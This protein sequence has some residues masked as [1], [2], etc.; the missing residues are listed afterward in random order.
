MKAFCW[1]T[2]APINILISIT[3]RSQF[4]K[5]YSIS[6]NQGWHASSQL[7][8]NLINANNPLWLTKFNVQCF[9]MTMFYVPQWQ[10]S[11]FLNDNVLQCSMFHGLQGPLFPNV[12]RCK[13]SSVLNVPS[14]SRFPVPQCSMFLDDNVQCSMVFEVPCSQCS[15]VFKVPCSPMFLDENVPQCSMFRGFQGFLFP[16]VP[17]SSITMFNVPWSLRFPVPNVPCLQMFNAHQ[18]SMS[19]VPQCSMFHNVQC[20]SML[21]A[22]C[23]MVFKVSCSQCSMFHVPWWQCS[24][25]HGL[26]GSLFPNV[27]RWL[28]SSM[29]NVPWPSTFPVPQC[30]M[31]LDDNVNVPWSSRFPVPNVPCLQMFNAHQCSMSHVPQ[32]SM[33]NNAQ[34]SSMIHVP[35]SNQT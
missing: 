33:F 27:P 28:C 16:N 24:M 13:C 34:C 7:S 30:S 23:S 29:F 6:N 18:C 1:K 10:C 35:C 4:L 19:H 8:G 15:M 14:P 2:Y 11:M 3:E 21:N 32:C 17:C 12:P 31:F 9:S 5:S 25:F 26:Q 20:S 22:Q